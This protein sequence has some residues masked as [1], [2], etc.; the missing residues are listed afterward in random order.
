VIQPSKVAP[1]GRAIS[2]VS[3]RR[4]LSGGRRQRAVRPV[5][6]Y[7]VFEVDEQ[8]HWMI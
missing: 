6:R 8:R 1:Q 5:L 3:V 7:E 2:P 4:Q